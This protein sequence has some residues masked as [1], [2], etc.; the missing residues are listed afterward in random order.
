RGPIG[1][2]E[3]AEDACNNPRTP[4]TARRP[5]LNARI[6]AP[7]KGDLL[8]IKGTNGSNDQP[9][10]PAT[11]TSSSSQALGGSEIDSGSPGPKLCC[12]HLLTITPIPIPESGGPLGSMNSS[13]SCRLRMSLQKRKTSLIGSD[14]FGTIS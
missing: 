8:S 1:S 13:T 9:A 3:I 7:Q 2:A 14:A 6:A 4:Q 12:H 10:A 11:G 5:R